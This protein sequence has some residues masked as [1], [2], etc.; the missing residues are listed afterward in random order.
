MRDI[1]PD[2]IE[3]VAFAWLARQRLNLESVPVTTGPG[4][5]ARILGAVYVPKK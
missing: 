1:D 3:A 4:A 2:A 5:T